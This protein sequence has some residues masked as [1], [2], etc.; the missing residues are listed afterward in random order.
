M[1]ETTYVA[2]MGGVEVGVVLEILDEQMADF[3]DIGLSEHVR[4][5]LF[6]QFP[7]RNG[8][9]R[10]V[11]RIGRNWLPWRI[12]N[13]VSA[14]HAVR[15]VGVRLEIRVLKHV[16]VDVAGIHDPHQKA[17]ELRACDNE[18]YVRQVVG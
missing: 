1:H 10:N 9:V 15:V 16:S 18:V 8:E 6:P 17:V 12:L 14:K 7:D 13:N 4:Y 11:E 5:R 2:K 3:V